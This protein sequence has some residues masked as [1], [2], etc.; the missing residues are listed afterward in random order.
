[1]RKY[2]A[3]VLL[4]ILTVAGVGF[5]ALG[6]VQS[7]SATDLGQ[8]VS[9]T[10]KA[11]NYSEY[12]VQK[13]TQGNQTANLVFQAPDRLSATLLASGHKTYLFII[14]TTE[15][16]AVT[17]KASAPMP[18]KFYTQKTTGAVSVDPAQQYLHF[19]K[20]GP[21]TRNGSVTTVTLTQ[22]GQKETLTYTVS[23][24]YVSNFHAATPDGT[25]NLA[26][27]EVGTSPPVALPKGYT[28][29]TTVPQA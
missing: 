25:I 27:S 9:N 26:I 3:F 2:M 1:M 11:P 15:Y 7:K 18:T 24:N 29:T 19:Y 4:G 12:L 28:I 8:A 5:A 14:G 22:G 16:I 21:S 10:L 17:T 13:T 6:V 23:G 20:E